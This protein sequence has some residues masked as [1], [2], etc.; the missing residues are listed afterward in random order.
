MTHYPSS[1]VTPIADWWHVVT[2]VNATAFSAVA[3]ESGSGCGI[4]GNLWGMVAG[5][6]PAQ[7]SYIPKPWTN[8]GGCVGE[9]RVKNLGIV[10]SRDVCE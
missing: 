7:Q 9:C 10:D 2:V 8:V 3:L 1:V 5:W 4:V 6:N